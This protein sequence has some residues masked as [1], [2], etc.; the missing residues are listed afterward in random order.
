M[1]K[2]KRFPGCPPGLGELLDRESD[3]GFLYF[4]KRNNRVL[5]LFERVAGEK[6]LGKITAY[7]YF[8]GTVFLRAD[9]PAY[10]ERF[11]YLKK[12]W[13]KAL[14]VELGMDLITDM[15]IKVLTEEEAAKDFP[16]SSEYQRISDLIRE[17]GA[18]HP[19]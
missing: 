14:N 4:I 2:D 5:K 3:R 11:N 1:A 9:S 7:R 15:R 6:Y 10:V 19:E 16:E 13:L 17:N 12:D 18:D 8:M